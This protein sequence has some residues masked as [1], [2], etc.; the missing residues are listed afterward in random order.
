MREGKNEYQSECSGCERR[1]KLQGRER[2]IM[3]SGSQ[4]S[5]VGIGIVKAV[6][7]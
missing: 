5:E 4:R 7:G 1:T 3:R 2:G 6:Y